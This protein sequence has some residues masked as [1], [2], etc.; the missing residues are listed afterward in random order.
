MTFLR[1]IVSLA[2]LAMWCALMGTGLYVAMYE[3]PEEMPTAQAIVV[4]GGNAPVNGTLTGESAARLEHGLS[5]FDAGAAPLLVMTGG[6]DI[7]VAP[8]M[9]TTATAAGVPEDAIL[10]EAA[11]RSTLQNAVFTADFAALDKEQPII[12]V[13]QRYHLPR[14]WASF[15][16]AGFQD[17]TLSAADPDD[18]LVLDKRLLWEAVKW[19]LNTLRAAAA[20][21]AMAAD[22]PRET[23]LKYLE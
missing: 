14:A 21:A 7:P 2:I 12:L 9:V 22:L 13:S 17:V 10:S 4:L 23:Y 16:W 20:S 15:R 5:L 8:T 1:W 6:G 18:G 3:P 11:S 19:P